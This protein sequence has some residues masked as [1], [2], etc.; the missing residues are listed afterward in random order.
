MSEHNKKRPKASK[1]ESVNFHKPMLS[2][3]QYRPEYALLLSDHIAK[4]FSLN[5]FDVGVTAKTLHDWLK[6]HEDFALARELGERRKLRLL[7]AAGIKMAVKDGN[8]QVWKVLMGQYGV[9]ERTESLHHHSHR[10]TSETGEPEPLKLTGHEERLAR[11]RELSKK[12]GIG[13]EEDVLEAEI[14]DES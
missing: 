1:P 8:S 7:E 3:N 13:A 2:H 12:L 4:G 9:H 11:I 5:S 10:H 14:E 6:T